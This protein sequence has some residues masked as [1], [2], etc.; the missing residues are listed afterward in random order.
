MGLGFAP[1]HMLVANKLRDYITGGGVRPG[2]RLKPDTEIASDF[3]VNKQTVANG[4]AILVK[5]G[6]ISRAP[7]RGTVALRT[8]ARTRR[9]SGKAVG[10]VVNSRGHVWQDM[11]KAMTAALFKRDLYPVF[12]SEDVLRPYNAKLIEQ[13]MEKLVMDEAAGLIVDGDEEMPFEFLRRNLPRIGSL[14]FINHFQCR[15]RIAGAR[16]VLTDYEEGGR[17][18]ARHLIAKGHR[19]LSFFGSVEMTKV[20]YIGSPQQQMRRG[21]EEVCAAAGAKFVYEIPERLAATGHCP[22][23]YDYFRAGNLL[24]DATLVV[25]DSVAVNQVWP[26]LKNLGLAVPGDI[27]LLGFFDTPW[28]TANPELQLSSFSIQETFQAETA[29]R[30]LNG[31]ID[32]LEIKTAPRLVERDSVAVAAAQAALTEAL[33]ERV[34]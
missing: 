14:V 5:E 8:S 25:S 6:L 19:K 9:S 10:I 13:F 18:A 22:A 34:M 4:M 7:G 17:E 33:I 32:D 23:N 27:S 11:A 21:M 30:M 31:E 3:G 24:P 16:C 1:K 29:V 12:I 26:N 15:E 20:G 28:T 2:D